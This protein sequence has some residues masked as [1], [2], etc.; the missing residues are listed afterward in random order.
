VA[1][2]AR[3]LG[4]GIAFAAGAGALAIAEGPGRSLTYAGRSGAAMVLFLTAGLALAAA[5]LMLSVQPRTGRIATVV[6]LASFA[7]FAPVFVAWQDGSPLVRSLALALTGFTLPLV[8]H[9]ALAFPGGRLRSNP[10]RVLVAAMYVEALLAAV[11]LA[12]FRDPYFDSSCWT[13]CTVNSFLVHSLP[14]FV[15]AVEVGDRWFVLAAATAV[16]AVCVGR[17]FHASHPARTR[18]AP[19]AVPAA[20]FALAVA[21]RV[22]AL[23]SLGVEDPYDATLFAIFVVS[24]AALILLGLG[25]G[26]SVLRARAERRALAQIVANL[27]D[28]P[29]PGELQAALSRA[30][31]DPDLRIAYRLAAEERYVDAQGRTVPEPAPAPGRTVTRLI[32]EERTI[33]LIAHTAAASEL[34]DQIGPAIR[35]GLEN[36]RLQAEVLAQLEELRASRVR[37]V[38]TADRARVAL[39][40]DLHDGAQQ[41]LLALSYDIRLARSS[42][43]AH[44]E[45]AAGEALARALDQAGT[46]IEELRDLARGIYPAV[47]TEAGLGAALDSLADTAALPVQIER[48]DDQRYPPGVEAAAYFAVA[49]AIDSAARCGAGQAIVSVLRQDGRLVVTIDDNGREPGSPVVTV[50]D[51]VGALGGDVTAGAAGWRVEIPCA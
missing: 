47:L 6:V 27:S 11:A 51:R 43:D 21:A 24:G 44:A 9:A 19:V 18:L 42:A 20:A 5:G 13:N 36:E 48:I 25:L 28:A 35:L 30:L 45:P 41:R 26:S 22:V 32:E 4:A 7:W 12:L 15:H 49:E 31:H 50:A 40:R 34:Q 1:V 17:L 10:V 38:E 23:Q 29:V 14:S 2:A 16:V 39:E 46:A 8:A 33:A 3:L 37:I